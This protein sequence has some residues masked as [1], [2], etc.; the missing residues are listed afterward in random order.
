MLKIAIVEDEKSHR[1]LLKSIIEKWEQNTQIKCLVKEFKSAEAFLFHWEES[2]DFDVLFLDI[3]MSGMDG[4]ELAKRIRKDDSRLA[5][6]FTTGIEDFLQ[7]G[8]EVSAL[9]YLLKPL[10]E[11]QVYACMDKVKSKS[12]NLKKSI[13]VPTEEGIARLRVND[14]LYIEAFGHNCKVRLTNKELSVKLG[15][16][17]I[18]K[19]LGDQDFVKCHR[20]YL[21]QIQHIQSIDKSSLTLD[22]AQQIPLSRRLYKEIN[23][24]FINY[25]ITEK[26]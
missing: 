6:V 17:E 13:V 3:Q 7:E 20:S 18:A 24:K 9:H 10:K 2:K 15:I 23:Q 1:T 8:Y 19:Q 11:Q 16:N 21:V 22:D 5:I 26:Q 12:E 25:Y 14:I 4:L